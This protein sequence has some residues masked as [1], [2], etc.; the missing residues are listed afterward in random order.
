SNS[1]EPAGEEETSGD[2]D[3]VFDDPIV[4]TEGGIYSGNWE[5]LDA[6]VPAVS[7]RTSEPVIIENSVIR[8]R[9]ACIDVFGGKARLTVR[10]TVGMGLNPDIAGRY[11]GRFLDVYGFASI[12][13]ENNELEGTSGIY[14]ADYLGNH[15]AAQ[16]VKIFRNVVSNVDGRVSD[17]KGGW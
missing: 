5:S 4:I 3:T 17:G 7:I 15:T 14:V 16:S 9:A 2:G 6:D 1:T 13:A 8:S 10:N 12:V 11:P